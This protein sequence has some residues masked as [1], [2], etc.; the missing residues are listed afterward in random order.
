[1]RTWPPTRFPNNDFVFAGSAV[2]IESLTL[3]GAGGH[4]GVA[5]MWCVYLFSGLIASVVG[6]VTTFIIVQFTKPGVP[7]TVAL[8]GEAE[9]SNPGTRVVYYKAPFAS[10]PYL[11]F[12]DGLGGYRITEEK[13]E[14]FKLERFASGAGISE[15]I[16]WKAEGRPAK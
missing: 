15:T 13:A 8:E 6:G 12:P 2:R 9:V 3:G 4:A 5:Q 1:M 16:R 10:P 11:T 14:S 7:Q